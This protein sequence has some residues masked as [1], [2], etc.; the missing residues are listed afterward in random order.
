MRFVPVSTL[1]QVLAVA[2]P[3]APERPRSVPDVPVRLNATVATIVFYI[4]GHGFGHASRD[5]EVINALLARR[6][7]C[8]SS[9]RTSAARWLFDL[10][11]V[12]PE[13]TRS[14]SPRARDRHRHRP[15]RQ[16]PPRRSATRCAARASSC[17]TFDDRVAARGRAFSPG[18]RRRL[19][20]ADIPPLESPP[21]ASRRTARGR[22]GQL[23]LG[24]DLLGLRRHGR[25]RRP[26]RRASMPHA[27]VALRL[28]M[29]GGFGFDSPRHRFALRR[30]SIEREPPETRRALGFPE[31]SVWC[32]SRSA[33]TALTGLDLD[34][35]A[36]STVTSWW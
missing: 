9:I 17:E 4:S 29:H 32:W 13:P 2:L 20:V 34:A 6:A 1:E 21:A 33:A 3:Q 26:T 27:E 30:P 19:V 36:D 25:S 7:I 5:I 22:A 35:L 15:D 18:K 23:H 16:S 28:P 24:L 31:R 10:T 11:R 8:E 12:G 14:C